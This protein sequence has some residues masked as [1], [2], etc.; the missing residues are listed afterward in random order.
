MRFVIFGIGHM[1][2]GSFSQLIQMQPVIIVTSKSNATIFFST[3]LTSLCHS[4]A[5]FLLHSIF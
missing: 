4:L 3:L 5:N 2:A 1:L